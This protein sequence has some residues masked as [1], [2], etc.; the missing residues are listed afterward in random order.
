MQTKFYQTVSVEKELP[1]ISG[2]Y[3]TNIGMIAYNS[4]MEHWH[5][6]SK[7]VYYWLKEISIQELMVEF[8]D[9]KYQNTFDERDVNERFFF[10]FKGDAIYTFKELVNIF[11]TEKGIIEK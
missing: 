10:N 3:H 1:T 7:D 5:I 4:A 6:H 11:L 2:N 8:L 9:W